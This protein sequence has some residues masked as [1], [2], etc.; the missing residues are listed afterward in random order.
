M[1]NAKPIDA[2]IVHC[3]TWYSHFGG[4]LAKILYGIPLV[5]TTHS[6][7]PLGRG[8]GNNSAEVTIYHHGSRRPL[9]RWQM[10]IVAVSNG[11]K[12]DILRNFDVEEA[13]IHVIPN[14]IDTEDIK[15]LI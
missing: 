11:T 9:F 8:N 2:D 7:E 6:L 3:H 5:I 13:K 14:G 15:R 10:P 12:D 4:I 1:F